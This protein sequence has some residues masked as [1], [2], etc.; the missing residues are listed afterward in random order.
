MFFWPRR[1]YADARYS[2]HYEI[3]KEQVEWPGG[4]LERLRSLTDQI[5]Q[6]RLAHLAEAAGTS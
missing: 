2:E 3:T 5:C 6:E 1:A 4:C